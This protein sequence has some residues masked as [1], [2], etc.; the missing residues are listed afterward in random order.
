MSLGV[1]EFRTASKERY[2]RGYYRCVQTL[3]LD[4]VA[5]ETHRNSLCELKLT[6]RE[7]WMVGGYT[8]DLTDHRTV[9]IGG[10]PLHED[11]RLP[12]TIQ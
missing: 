5:P 6:M 10:G 7:F 9:K 3:L 2:G 4:V 8:E 12:G 1:R 11:G